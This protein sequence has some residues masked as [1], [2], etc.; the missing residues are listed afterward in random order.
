MSETKAYINTDRELWR[1]TPGDYYAP[2]I[3]VTEHGGIGINVGGNVF[4]KPLRAWHA[5][6]MAEPE[7]DPRAEQ[8]IAKL[9]EKWE[10]ATK[11]NRQEQAQNG[12][13]PC[14]GHRIEVRERCTQ[15]KEPES[16]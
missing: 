3:H 9:V 6:A 7:R 15:G 13:H 1:E 4:I 16:R 8:V 14:L 5:L 10:A 11:W 2:S 12:A